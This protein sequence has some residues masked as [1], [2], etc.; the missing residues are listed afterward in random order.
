MN[1]CFWKDSFF[2]GND[3]PNRVG[4][5]A[6]FGPTLADLIDEYLSTCCP[7]PNY[8]VPR[9]GNADTTVGNIDWLNFAL[10]KSVFPYEKSQAWSHYFYVPGQGQTRYVFTFPFMHFINQEIETT[11][12][13]R[14]DTEENECAIPT[15]KFISPGLPAPGVLSGEV[16][17]I[18]TQE[19]S[20][21]CT[22]NE[23]WLS[24]DLTVKDDGPNNFPR[25]LRNAPPEAWS[26][27]D[28]GYPPAVLP[29]VVNRGDGP[30]ADVFDVTPM[31]SPNLNILIFERE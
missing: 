25:L 13:A 30:T 22:F 3:I 16:T 5:G 19:P 15:G 6:T 27:L 1:Y 24:F 12:T 8:I 11:K 9:N 18:D 4:A 7:Y 20:D 21:P 31:H 26:D 23:G 29:V 28:A 14:F 17:I 2:S 10:S